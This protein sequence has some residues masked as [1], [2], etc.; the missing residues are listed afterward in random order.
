MRLLLTRHWETEENIAGIKQWHL[1]GKLSKQGIIQAERLA[2]RLKDEKIDFIYSSDL[3]R[4]ADTANEI[5]K[6]HEDA[7][8]SFVEEL[9]ER[10]LWNLQWKKNSELWLS[11][12]KWT[13]AHKREE[14]NMVVNAGGESTKEAYNRAETFLHKVLSEHPSS[15]VLFVSHNRFWKHIA[16]VIAWKKSNEVR[17]LPRFQ[18]TSLSEY[19]IDEDKNHEI[20]CY[21]CTKH[22]E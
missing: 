14:E 19:V 8:I 13:M 1:P 9:R 15:T 17:W 12:Q 4:A 22:L 6:Y 11:E 16:A 20:I 10:N 7:P 2:K 5:A 21:N 3:A 18:N